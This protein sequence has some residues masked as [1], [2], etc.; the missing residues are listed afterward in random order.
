[1]DGDRIIVEVTDRGRGFDPELVRARQNSLGLAGLADRVRLVGGDLDIF[2]RPG[3]GSRI[4]A[5]FPLALA[6][7]DA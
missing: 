7:P 4:Q 1:M 6:E 3:Q 2:S 5:S